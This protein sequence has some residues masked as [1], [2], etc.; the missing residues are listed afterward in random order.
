MRLFPWLTQRWISRRGRFVATLMVAALFLGA[1]IP[2]SPVAAEGGTFP[3]EPF[4]GMQIVYDVSGATL[5][6]PVDEGGFTTTRTYTG[7]LSGGTLTVSGEGRMGG[8]YGAQL[9]V[10]VNAGGESNSFSAYIPTGWPSY[11]SQP[12]S[13][14]VPIPADSSG[15]SF[16]I[17]M[18]GEYNAGTRGLVVSG[19]LGAGSGG[20]TL[21]EPVPVATLPPMTDL[22]VD[23]AVMEHLYQFL[24]QFDQDCFGR[25]ARLG[26][27]DM[28]RAAIAEVEI[29][30]DPSLS[31]NSLYTPAGMFSGPSLTLSR[32]P[33]TVSGDW[34]Y[35]QTIWHELTHR[36]EDANGDFGSPLAGQDAYDERN[37]QYMSQVSSDLKAFQ[38]I[39]AGVR[40]GKP[41][42]YLQKVWR[43]HIASMRNAEAH[44]AWGGMAPDLDQIESWTGFRARADEIEALYASGACGELMQA[45]VGGDLGEPAPGL[46]DFPPGTFS[47]PLDG[48]VAGLSEVQG[49]GGTYAGSH[50]VTYFEQDGR[51]VAGLLADASYL[52]LEPSELH[53]VQGTL[54]MTY[55]PAP[56]SPQIYLS[57]HP[58]WTPFGEYLAPHYGFILDTVGWEGAHP[59]AFEL[60]A[61]PG[62]FIQFQIFDGSAWHLA[63]WQTPAEFDWGTVD[64]QVGATYGPLGMALIVDGE[65][66]AYDPYPGGVDPTAAWFVGQAPWNWP[67]G[68]HT[69]VGAYSD[70][71]IYHEQP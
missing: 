40:E 26:D 25:V 60:T 1:Q 35:Q 32:D 44:G 45:I 62:G 30:V 58:T 3:G 19:D 52:A 71:R 22:P 48:S 47:N 55:R 2:A 38:S 50:E 18:T 66:R 9:E 43:D 49:M 5:D 17:V 27:G 57:D 70:L 15:G 29:S 20:G 11:N 4:N 56:N 21:P 67:Y 16:S 63:V 36:R 23:Q 13:V 53:P 51:T 12:F 42:P 28:Y 14:S 65:I 37:V 68:P 54:L 59:G 24:H 10:S 6:A 41:L 31:A 39:E 61:Q 7:T 34:A 8:G 33:R 64:H 69:L 46:G